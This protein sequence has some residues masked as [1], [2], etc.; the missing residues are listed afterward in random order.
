M[1]IST[2]RRMM[3]AADKTGE[4][5]FV[6]GDED[7]VVQFPQLSLDELLQKQSET[8]KLIVDCEGDYQLIISQYNNLIEYHNGLVQHISEVLKQHSV[9]AIPVLKPKKDFEERMALHVDAEEQ[10]NE[11]VE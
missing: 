3:A 11:P 4:Y 9:R 5:K 1:A 2:L 7:K 8:E 6:D 10:G